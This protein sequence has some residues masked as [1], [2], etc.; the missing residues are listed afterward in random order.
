MQR[1]TLKIAQP[2]QNIKNA[3]ISTQNDD[4]LG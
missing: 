4:N 1:T 2:K 3:I